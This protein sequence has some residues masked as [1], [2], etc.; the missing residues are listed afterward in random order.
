M[1]TNTTEKICESGFPHPAGDELTHS[2]SHRS[3]AINEATK[4]TAKVAAQAADLDT[5]TGL[6][7]IRKES[8]V[9]RPAHPKPVKLKAT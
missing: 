6:Q 3:S 2:G 7:D 4:L 5:Q 8:C 1:N 9:T